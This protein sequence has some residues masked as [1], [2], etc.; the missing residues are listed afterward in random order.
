MQSLVVACGG[1]SRWLPAQ[2]FWGCRIILLQRLRSTVVV[3]WV[4]LIVLIEVRAETRF[5]QFRFQTNWPA[6]NVERLSI[7]RGTTAR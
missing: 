2:P 3:R 5:N 7:F 4:L 6:R 1:Q